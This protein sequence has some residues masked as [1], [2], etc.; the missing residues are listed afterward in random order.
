[1]SELDN[2]PVPTPIV[3][4]T[5]RELIRIEVEKLV[6]KTKESLNEVQRIAIAEAWKILQLAVASVIQVIEAI[7]S[8]LS[9]PEKK[10]LAM[11]LLNSFYDS[12]FVV[13]DIPVVPNF[14]EP[15]IHK[16]I[17]AFL[18]ILVSSTIDAL[19]TTFRNT[20]VFLKKSN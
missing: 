13:V 15:I 9:S 2:L 1:M 16:Y 14:L 11:G 4:L 6:A 3:P 5:S 8:D 7:G 19:V 10:E 17:K 12:V 18:M 20:G